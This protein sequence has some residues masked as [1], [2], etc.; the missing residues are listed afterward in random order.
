MKSKKII[1]ALL[2]SMMVFSLTACNGSTE[3]TTDTVSEGTVS[4]AEA[5]AATDEVA[6][7][8]SIDFEDG[9]FLSDFALRS[10]VHNSTL[11]GLLFCGRAD[12]NGRNTIIP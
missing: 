11:S 7:N 9:L 12:E 4:D 3:A 1:A 8:P 2:A 10:P 6:V 5:E